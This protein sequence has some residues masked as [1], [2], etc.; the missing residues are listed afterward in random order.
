MPEVNSPTLNAKQAAMYIGVSYWTLLSLVRKGLIKHFK[1][2]NK[3]LFRQQTLDEWMKMGEE[4]SIS[5]VKQ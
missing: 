1:G 2:G 4:E 3:L 5:R